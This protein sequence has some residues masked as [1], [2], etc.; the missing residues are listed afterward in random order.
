[1]SAPIRLAKASEVVHGGGVV[2]GKDVL[3]LLS[4]AMYVDPLTIYR[5][6][7]QNAADAIDAARADGREAGRIDIILDAA[8]RTIAIRDDAAG[9]P[10]GEF[11]RVL[12]SV[13]ASGK[14]GTAARGFRGVGRLSGLAYARS[15]TFQSR[16]VGEAHVSTITWNC[17]AL[18]TALR[19]PADTRDL[20]SIIGAITTTTITEEAGDPFFE[21]RLEGV[22]RQGDDR[23][24]SPGAV[25]DYLA[26]VAPVPLDSSFSHA[27]LISEMLA[28][29]VALGDLTVTIN[30]GERL[31]RPFRDELPVE[32][33]RPLRLREVAF[34]EVPS[35][36]GGVGAVGWIAHH[37]YEGAIH[38]KTHV[39][40]L[41]VRAGD[42]QIGEAG[43]LADIFPETRFDAWTVGEIHVLD[44]RIV[45]NGRR[46]D[47]ERNVHLANLKNHLAP[48]GRD[49][50]NRCRTSSRDRK[51]L[52]DIELEE[53]SAREGIAVLA[54][55]SLAVPERDRV[56]LAVDLALMRA[57]KL[58]GPSD[59][60]DDV[61]AEARGRIAEL[62]SELEQVWRDDAPPV[63]PLDRLPPER[64]AFFQEMFAL[65]YENS[66][67]RA[68]AK[69]LVDRIMA[70]IA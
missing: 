54:Q 35:V 19:D 43:V 56:A 2:V 61:G 70:K 55:G 41:R 8:A 47:F 16:A 32:G 23:V 3:E 62:R 65:I 21:V 46:D 58:V 57:G 34:V 14:R 67:N 4:T 11:R 18:R 30:D 51:R 48:L 39:R 38:P 20:T 12:T 66:Q 9:I 45:P 69:S 68:A 63:S 6:Y 31:T 7:V 44:S 24:M 37:D 25:G 40:G 1:M 42:I 22:A 64:R 13:G 15:L 59:R 10:A 26:E 27:A 33:G 49:V 17:Q 60:V 52:R 50:A 29:A 53:A 5:E 28:G 36:D